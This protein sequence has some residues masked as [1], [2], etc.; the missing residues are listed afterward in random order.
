M[1]KEKSAGAVVVNQQGEFLLVFEKEAKYWGFP[2]GH[3]EKRETD[4][5][6][7]ERELFEET[8]ITM[9]ELVDG[10]REKIVYTL[11]NGNIKEATFF[12]AKTSDSVKLSEEHTGF[13][14]CSGKEAIGRIIHDNLKKI[15][16][17]AMKHLETCKA[18][19]DS[20]Y[21]DI[22]EGYEN[23]H[24]EEQLSKAR[25]INGS[26]GIKNS[27]KLLDVG[28]GT[29]SYL[30]IFGCNVFG[31]DPSKGLLKKNKHPN[32]QAGAEKIPFADNSFDIVTCITAIHLFKDI[33]K[34]LLEM[35]RVGKKLFAFS[36]L[37]KSSKFAAIDNLVRKHFFVKK[38]VLE[39]KDAIYFL[40]K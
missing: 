7:M 20:Y 36:V 35:K 21:D 38:I 26:L 9:F 5:E 32:T 2:K 14:W 16:K 39:E 10:F 6:T 27:D 15:L 40:E 30:G 37:K 11:P 8:G 18:E 29:G 13:C 28:C 4:R 31:I 33:E 22:S 19:N 12:L 23:L 24:S 25:I 17:K 34:G 1:K 3:K